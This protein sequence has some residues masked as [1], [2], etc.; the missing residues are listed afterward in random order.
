MKNISI[1]QMRELGNMTQK[2]FGSLFGLSATQ[3]SNYERGYDGPNTKSAKVLG[4]M[5]QILEV[6]VAD[7]VIDATRYTDEDIEY[8]IIQNQKIEQNIQEKL[9]YVRVITSVGVFVWSGLLTLVVTGWV[10]G[11][12]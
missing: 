2:D 6:L 1:K 10:T 3:V 11:I 8:K 5:E 12:L 4:T 9:K 7:N